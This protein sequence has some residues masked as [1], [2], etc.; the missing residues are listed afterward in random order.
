MGAYILVEEDSEIGRAD[1]VLHIITFYP[2]VIRF[3]CDKSHFDEYRGKNADCK[4]R[5]FPRKKNTDKLN[6]SGQICPA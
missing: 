1:A 5:L 4:A 6:L 3:F 2:H